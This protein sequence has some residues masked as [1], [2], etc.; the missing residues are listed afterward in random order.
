MKEH[1]ILFTPEMVKA[2]LDGRKTQTRRVIKLPGSFSSVSEA[3]DFDVD[4]IFINGQRQAWWPYAFSK[5]TGCLGAIKCPYGEAGDSLWVRETWMRTPAGI[6]YRADGNSHYGA[7]VQLPWKPSIHMF[8]SDSRLTLKITDIRVERVQDISEDDCLNE[9]IVTRFCKPAQ[10]TDLRI[11]FRELWDSI[12][13]KRGL[14]WEV[15]P[16]VW[17]LTFKII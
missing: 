17:A 13:K 5:K 14:G 1:P 3:T 16:Y 11:K 6:F 4:D 7:G 12:N 9:G 15:N 10:Y 8:R 2:I